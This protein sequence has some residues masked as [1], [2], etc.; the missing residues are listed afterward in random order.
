[1]A[2][3]LPIAGGERDPVCGMTVVP[4]TAAARFEYGGKAYFFCAVGCMERFR[5]EPEKYLAPKPAAPAPT[6]DARRYT[7]PMHPEVRQV[8]PGACPKCGMGLE[9][10]TVTL[11]AVDE[12]NPELRDMTRRFWISAALALPALVIAMGEMFGRTGIWI[13][14]ALATPVVLWGGAPFFARGWASVKNRS[15]NMFTLIAMGTGV[16]YVYSLVATLAPRALPHA[17]QAHGGAAPVYFEA[18]A[19]I[20]ALVLL[21]QV[22]ELRARSRTSSAIRALLGLAPKTARRVR[23]DHEQDVALADVVPGDLLRVRPGEKVPVDGVVVE[24]TSSIDESMVSGEAI[25]VEKRAGDRVTGGTVNGTGSF[26]MRAERVGAETLLARIVQMVAE[27]QRS[28]API[29]RLADVVASRFV[30]AVVAISAL[31]FAA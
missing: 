9:A 5:G 22:L 14:L 24:G 3:R 31:P 21:G 1:M 8:G 17:F 16:A 10:E 30:P 28:R 29:Q 4:A 26:V 2:H 15:P 25:P 20:T 13:Q 23:G 11:G 18:A 6:T 19:V 12:A 7:C 27:A